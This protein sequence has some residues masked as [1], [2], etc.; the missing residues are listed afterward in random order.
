MR[1]LNL[2]KEVKVF[3][4]NKQRIQQSLSPHIFECSQS[5]IAEY[6][7]KNTNGCRDLSVGGPPVV[8]APPI[9]RFPFQ[10]RLSQG[11]DSQ[12]GRRVGLW[13]STLTESVSSNRLFKARKTNGGIKRSPPPTEQFTLRRSE[14]SSLIGSTPSL[15]NSLGNISEKRRAEPIKVNDESIF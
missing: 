2:L 10:R 11:S 14:C 13:S 4:E 12:S 15:R 8:V 7:S 6:H 9:Y 3:I 5:M 1:R